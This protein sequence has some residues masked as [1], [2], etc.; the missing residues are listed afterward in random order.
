M[1]FLGH[2]LFQDL[3]FKTQEYK[4]F[5]LRIKGALAIAIE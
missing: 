1:E 5:E 2:L 4:K 3:V